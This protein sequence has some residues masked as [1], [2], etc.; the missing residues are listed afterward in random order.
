[1]SPTP[2]DPSLMKT[3][4]ADAVTQFLATSPQWRHSTDR[5][6]L[7]AREFVFDTFAGAFGFMTQIALAAE[8]MNHHPEWSNIYDRVQILLTTHDAGGLSELDIAMA[9]HADAAYAGTSRQRQPPSPRHP[10]DALPRTA[11]P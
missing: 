9:L 10:A 7:L 3:L 4:N 5:G 6:G 11:T 8:R 2:Q 1:M